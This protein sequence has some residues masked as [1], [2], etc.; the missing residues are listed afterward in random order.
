MHLD[1][2]FQPENVA[3]ATINLPGATYPNA[4]TRVSFMERALESIRALPGVEA[5]GGTSAIPFGGNGNSNVILGE[6]HVMQPGESLLAPMQLTVT[7]G[8]FEAMQIGLAKGRLFDAR[9][10]ADATKT[11]I[12][13][14]RLA[15][16]FWPGQDA[17]GRRL[18]APSDPKDITK[19]TKDTQF[20][21]IVG[22]V[23]N[24]QM[25]DPRP[26]VKAVGAFYFPYAQAPAGGLTL[27][28]R[29]RAPSSTIQADI[30]RAVNTIDPQLPLSK[31]Q[32]M[33][34]WIDQA[35]T[36][37]RMPMLIAIAF[38]IVALFL[39]SVGIYGVLAYGVA[40]RRREMG[41]RMA[42]GGS[43]SD[44]F[45][46][47]ASDGVKIIVVGLLVGLV[48]AFFVGQLMTNLLFG[49]TPL[50]PLVI[51]GMTLTLVLVALVAS[52]IPAWRATTINPIVVLGKVGPRRAVADT[53]MQPVAIVPAAG[54]GERFGG[55]KLAADV[56]GVPMLARVVHALL[57]GGAMQVI[58]VVG[59]HSSVPVEAIADPRVTTVV[60]PEPA[61]GMFSSIQAGAAVAAGDP[62]LVLPGDMPFVRASTV[63]AV[64]QAYERHQMIV[65]PRFERRRGHPIVLP[66]SMRL[67]ILAAPPDGTLADA[68]ARARG[69]AP[70]RR[71]RRFRRR[72]GRRRAAGPPLTHTTANATP[73]AR[74]GRT[75]AR[76]WTGR[77]VQ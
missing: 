12:I 5:A 40:Q 36:G 63:A 52:I 71:R 25:L 45:R 75:P 30:S 49:V 27:A 73:A 50:D 35:L 7:P 44:I 32:P 18:Y 1:L 15:D 62:I 28:V 3:T 51:A 48:G 38:G 69:G 66:A 58:V 74:N 16:K 55:P 19:I 9:D 22:V 23:K 56:D 39:S 24:V 31:A 21:L 6:G 54:K 10:T 76:I 65:S 70:R 64:L 20:F 68:A 11:A 41:V 37:R 72:Q 77:P 42:L 60:N 2:G 4:A 34:A 13:D 43:G 8:Y 53:H 26:D 33:Q 14:E 47:V 17:V 59:P 46:L 29:T 61:R 57:A 67:E